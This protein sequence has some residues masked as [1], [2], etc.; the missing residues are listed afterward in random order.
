MERAPNRST[1]YSER[2]EY[3]KLGAEFSEIGQS[4][5]VLAFESVDGGLN[6]DSKGERPPGGESMET[7][8][9]RVALGP[10]VMVPQ[11][12]EKAEREVLF[13]TAETLERHI[14]MNTQRS[15]GGVALRDVRRP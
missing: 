13:E 4:G 14:P 8:L 11:F 1:Q 6:F 7:L 9:G 12:A 2:D 3:V 5:T 15:L 10:L